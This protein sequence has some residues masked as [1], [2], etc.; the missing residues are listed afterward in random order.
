MSTSPNVPD[1]QESHHYETAAGTPRWI[2]LLFAV[3]FLGLGALIYLNLSARTRAEKDNSQIQEQNR[4]LSAQLEQA[5]SRVADLKAHV[6]ATEQKLGMTAAD[7]AQAKARAEVIRK[8]QKEADTR[9][10][11]GLKASE[12]HIG[13]VA[14]EV[15]G[16]KK[17]IESTR[18]D[19]EVTKAKLDRALGDMGVM[20]GLIARSREDLD[21]LRR[22]G[23]RN[24]Y[25][26]T[27]RK[28]KSA[29]RVGPVQI[30][31]SKADPKK[32]RYTMTV[33]VDD[34]SIEKK[35]RT[36]G[37]PVQFYVKGAART[38]PYEIVVFEVNKDQ[39]S[40]YLA[41]PKDTREAPAPAAAPA[42]TEK[43]G[44]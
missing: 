6:E 32:G 37:E 28:S 25:D 40:G 20:S 2:A 16:A 29:E 39:A 26:F 31:L 30:L 23:D 5:N 13:A 17:D 12:E 4:I 21:Q 35:D 34:K 41:T 18:T 3:V 7:I 1:A 8:E 33:L 11:A 9:L 14:T 27:L 19:L 44:S 36:V 22:K 42:A 38:F 24:Y 15:G 10:T 43:P